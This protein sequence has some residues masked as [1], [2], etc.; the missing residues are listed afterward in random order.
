MKKFYYA[1]TANY[2]GMREYYAPEEWDATPTK[3]KYC[4][5]TISADE[6]DNLLHVFNTYGRL[7]HI[8][9]FPTKK[10]A[11]EVAAYWNDCYKKNGTY[12]L[13]V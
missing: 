3:E 11:E 12:A 6:S 7:S 5:F 4:A 13:E 10:R 2:T 8:N 9:A 1:A